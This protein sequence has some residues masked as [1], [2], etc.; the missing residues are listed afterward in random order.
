MNSRTSPA[1]LAPPETEPGLVA[2]LIARLVSRCEAAIGSRCR[3]IFRMAANPGPDPLPVLGKFLL[4]LIRLLRVHPELRA[5]SEIRAQRDRR[6]RAHALPFMNDVVQACR[7]QV[8]I[9]CNAAHAEAHLPD[10]LREQG[11]GMGC[12]PV[13][14]QSGH[15]P[16]SAGRSGCSVPLRTR[17]LSASQAYSPARQDANAHI[18]RCSLSRRL[19]SP[20]F[21]RA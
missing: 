6:L 7:R 18:A 10:L 16:H 20:G 2:V 1:V 5:L 3:S 19:P 4:Q 12:D 21:G 14:G 15:F 8:D 9:P 17:R 11:A 13:R